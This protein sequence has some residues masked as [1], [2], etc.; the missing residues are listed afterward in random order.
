MNYAVAVPISD[1]SSV[2]EARRSS[3]LAAERAGFD[4][5]RCNDF[6]L[7]ATEVSRN[8][9]RHGAGGQTVIEVEKRGDTPV[10]RILA[11]DNGPG[12]RE[13]ERSFE[14]GYSTGGTLGIGMGAMKRTATTFDIFTSKSG[15]VVFMELANAK[16]SEKMQIAGVAVP[17]PGEIR[18]GDAWSYVSS[19]ERLVVLLVDGLGHGKSAADA[20]QE[21]VSTFQQQANRSPGEIMTYLHG[22]LKKTRGAAGAV[23]EIDFRTK[24]LTYAGVGNISGVILSRA[25]SRNLVSHNGTLGAIMVRNQEFK[26]EW[27][28][29]GVL[30]MHSDGIQ[31][32]WDLSS[33]P[34]LMS[35][36][37]A[38]I[39]GVMLRDFRRLRDDASVLIVKKN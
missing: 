31:S 28:D 38:V 6:A 1:E 37:A 29:D 18:C 23:A 5:T 3:R 25:V 9:L 4:E 32:R 35:R 2:G 20:A 34:G 16:S 11:L 14:D 26:F 22:A 8:V 27:P 30:I 33:Y 12:L 7:L 36:H 19:P 10:G 24:Q 21:A 15:T 13:I 39:G 17:Y